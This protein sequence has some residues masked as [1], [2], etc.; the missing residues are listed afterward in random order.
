MTKHLMIGAL[1]VLGAVT[2]ALADIPF[3]NAT[4]PSHIEVHS[5]A[6]GPVYLNGNEAKLHR[7]NANY[8]EA[9]RDHITVSISVNPD[10]SLAVSYTKGGAN[11][12]CQVN[13]HQR[14]GRKVQEPVAPKLAMTT[15]EM[16]RFCR[17]EAAS[18]FNVRP[19]DL[20]VNSAF[21]VGN[22]YVSQGWFDGTR[23]STFFN[24]FFD[25]QGHFQSLN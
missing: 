1:L 22:R 15:S 11:G 10:N 13:A 19:A 20:T 9:V 17:G 5:D 16:S 8:Y 12:I 4:C 7:F 21:K 24:C 18:H 23:G 3:F 2:P 6:G 14:Q 25:G